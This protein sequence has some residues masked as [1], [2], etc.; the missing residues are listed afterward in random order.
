MV[1]RIPNVGKSTFINSYAGKACK[2]GNKPGPSVTR[3]TVDP[4]E[5][6]DRTSGCAGNLWPK[7]EDQSVVLKLAHRFDPG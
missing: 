7:F 1:V 4:A 2:D 5:Q 3:K 6:D